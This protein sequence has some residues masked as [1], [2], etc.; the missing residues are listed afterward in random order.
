[1]LF[2][3]LRNTVGV[4]FIPWSAIFYSQRQPPQLHFDALLMKLLNHLLD[5]IT[6]KRVATRLPISV[7]VEPSIIQSRPMDSQFLQ[8]GNGPQHLRRS[9][10][11]EI[12]PA[13]PTHSVVFTV[14]RSPLEAFAVNHVGVHSQR[15]VVVSEINC[16]E[17]LRCGIDLAWLQS[18][19]WREVNA[20]SDRS[21]SLGLYRN[22]QNQGK[23]FHMA[24][25]FADRPGPE[26]HDRDSSADTSQISFYLHHRTHLVL[27]RKL[28]GHGKYVF[29]SPLD[30]GPIEGPHLIRVCG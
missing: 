21:A 18:A 7:I 11:G 13:A 12:A 1:M 14:A 19:V 8:L 16:D 28:P 26:G 2:H 17:R 20:C 9:Y 30:A 29:L 22:R 15:F 5:F 23:R 6:G 24:D 4:R 27:L 10:I 25:G 3:N